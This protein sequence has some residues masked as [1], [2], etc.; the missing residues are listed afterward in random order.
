MHEAQKKWIK[1]PSNLRLSVPYIKATLLRSI[2]N[3]T[4][5]CALETEKGAVKVEVSL[6]D[7]F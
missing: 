7:S 3:G 5:E 1:S 2:A 4:A 6:N